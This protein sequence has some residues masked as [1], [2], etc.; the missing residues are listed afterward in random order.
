MSSSLP[1]IKRYASSS[2]R[3]FCVWCLTGS[4]ADFSFCSGDCS[5]LSSVGVLMSV[6]G[7]DRRGLVVAFN[8]IQKLC[9][10]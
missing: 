10:S 2:A 3:S 5:E 6:M 7:L 4:V 9:G 1:V 8:R